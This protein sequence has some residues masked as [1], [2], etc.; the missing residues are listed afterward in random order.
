[1]FHLKA[2]FVSRNEHRLGYT[3][4]NLLMLYGPK[5]LLILRHV[6]NT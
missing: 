1:V 2:Q 4:R 5:S 6:Q 3:K